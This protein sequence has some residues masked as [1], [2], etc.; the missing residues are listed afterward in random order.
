MD[1][2]IFVGRRVAEFR[3]RTGL[4]QQALGV[5]FGVTAADIAAY[6]A[7]EARPADDSRSDRRGS[8]G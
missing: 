3:K 1:T 2:R 7:G 6:E 4:D 5:S 8:R